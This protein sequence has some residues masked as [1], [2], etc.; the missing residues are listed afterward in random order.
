[1]SLRLTGGEPG[2]A[3]DLDSAPLPARAKTRASF[4][5]RMGSKVGLAAEAEASSL[6][7]LAIAALVSGILLSAGLAV[8]L[9]GRRRHLPVTYEDRRGRL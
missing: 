7:L 6:G 1:M 3:S 2:A 9:S 4:D 8:R 5:V